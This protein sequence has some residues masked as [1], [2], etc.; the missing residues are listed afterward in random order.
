MYT[1]VNLSL[2]E[3]DFLL[4]CMTYASDDMT[5]SMGNQLR[6][7]NIRDNLKLNRDRLDRLMNEKK[8]SKYWKCGGT[9][10]ISDHDA[11]V[12]VDCLMC[13]GTGIDQD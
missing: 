1:I 9:G 8:K 12:P 5:A 2:D 11:I 3:I 4:D 7:Q 10:V 13:D 6:Y